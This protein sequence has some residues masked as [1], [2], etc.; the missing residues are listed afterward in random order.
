ME[1]SFKQAL[2]HARGE[3]QDL[4]TIVLS[5]QSKPIKKSEGVNVPSKKS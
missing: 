4:R 3:R 1:A 2:Q 5:A